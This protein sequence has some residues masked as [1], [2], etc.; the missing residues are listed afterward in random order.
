MFLG[1]IVNI[2]SLRN[3]GKNPF[4]L[5][6]FSENCFFHDW[7]IDGK[8]VQFIFSNLNKKFSSSPPNVT[9]LKYQR[10]IQEQLRIFV[11]CENNLLLIWQSTKRH[12]KYAEKNF[13]CFT[14]LLLVKISKC[15]F[16]NLLIIGLN[17]FRT[18]LESKCADSLVPTVV[19]TCECTYL[20]FINPCTKIMYNH[21]SPTELLKWPTYNTAQLLIHTSNQA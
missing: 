20:C 19:I 2:C 13:K 5:K 21:D 15:F 18:A 17:Y 16:K 12:Q 4:S 6:E 3:Q 10:Y 14:E 9:C 1:K 11:L 8:S 7:L